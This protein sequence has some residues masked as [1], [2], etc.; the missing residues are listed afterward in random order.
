M[1]VN[2]RLLFFQNR[3]FSQVLWL[4][5]SFFCGYVPTAGR[6]QFYG[7]REPADAKFKKILFLL[8]V[9]MSGSRIR[10]AGRFKPCAHLA[11][12]DLDT[13]VE[14]NQRSRK[15]RLS[16]FVRCCCSYIVLLLILVLSNLFVQWQCPICLKNYQL[17]NII[18]DPYF[19]RITSLVSVL[20]IFGF[21]F[22][23][24]M[25]IPVLPGTNYSLLNI[26]AKL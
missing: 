8:C 23:H 2:T 24:E 22:I 1:F 10:V 26:D 7:F 5:S 18:I 19:N 6:H 25:V 15:V 21:V 9:Q 3:K 17:E 20:V 14:L 12:F 11:C 4:F 16:S 13:F